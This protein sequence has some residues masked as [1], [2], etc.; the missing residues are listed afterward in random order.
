MT[1]GFF[2]KGRGKEGKEIPQSRYSF[3]YP[4]VAPYSIPVSLSQSPVFMTYNYKHLDLAHSPHPTSLLHHWTVQFSSLIPASRSDRHANVTPR[5]CRHFVTG[6][7]ASPF[8]LPQPPI[9]LLSCQSC[10]LQGARMRGGVDSTKDEP[11]ERAGAR[12]DVV[13]VTSVTGS[14]LLSSRAYEVVSALWRPRP[15]SA[16]RRC[17]RARCTVVPDVDCS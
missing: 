16:W 12:F 2:P 15:L 10:A 4:G 6:I 3:R 11:L 14:V 9:L 13:T 7:I 17:P 5:R 1:S 8:L